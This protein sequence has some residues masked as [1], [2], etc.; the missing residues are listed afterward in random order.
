MCE[1]VSADSLFQ[2]NAKAFD[3]VIY[4][5][6][7]PRY[8]SVNICAFPLDTSRIT[9]RP[10]CC[11]VLTP[12]HTI[13]KRIVSIWCAIAYSSPSPQVVVEALRITPLKLRN[14]TRDA[15]AGSGG[16]RPAVPRSR[17][18]D[19]SARDPLQK[20][21]DGLQQAALQMDWQLLDL[22]HATLHSQT[23]LRSKCVFS[24]VRLE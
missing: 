24:L 3:S 12:L 14:T 21:V 18:L 19:W 23:R 8:R 9:G 10:L 1:K 6:L 5:I 11:E 20:P 22:H 7:C 2:A 13:E 4:F 16:P 15:L 17:S